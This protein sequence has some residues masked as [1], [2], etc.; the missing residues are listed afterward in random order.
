MK[1]LLIFTLFGVALTGGG[2]KTYNP[3][4]FNRGVGVFGTTVLIV[5]FSQLKD[6]MWYNE[7]WRGDLVSDTLKFWVTQ[8]HGADFPD[9]YVEDK[10]NREVKDWTGESISYNCLECTKFF[11]NRCLDLIG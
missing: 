6:E 8:H 3:A 2:C 11:L 1:R 9:A 5:P 4:L 10:I 7:S